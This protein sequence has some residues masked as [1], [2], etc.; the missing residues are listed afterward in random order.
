MPLAKKRRNL[1]EC[2]QCSD[3]TLKGTVDPNDG[4]FYCFICW[5]AFGGIPEDAQ[6]INCILCKKSQVPEM[7][8]KTQQKKKKPICKNCIPRRR[9][10][11]RTKQAQLQAKIGKVN[12]RLN[13]ETFMF[14]RRSGSYILKP[15]QVLTHRLMKNFENAVMKKRRDEKIC[16]DALIGVNNVQQASLDYRSKDKLWEVTS[17]EP[18]RSEV[19]D[20]DGHNKSVKNYFTFPPEEHS[21]EFICDYALTDPMHIYSLNNVVNN[22]KITFIFQP[23]AMYDVRN[24]YTFEKMRLLLVTIFEI[25]GKFFQKIWWPVQVYLE[26]YIGCSEMTSNIITAFTGEV[27]MECS[28]SSPNLGALFTPW[29]T[30]EVDVALMG[31]YKKTKKMVDTVGRS[32]VTSEEVEPNI[33]PDVKEESQSDVKET[34]SKENIEAETKDSA[35]CAHIVEK[36]VSS[37][38]KLPA[39]ETDLTVC[40]HNNEETSSDVN[41][42]ANEK[43]ASVEEDSFEFVEAAV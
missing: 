3:L 5:E 29:D 27:L 42:Q 36:K 19:S 17:E 32:T 9:Q 30:W 8:S 6:W 31:N 12:K 26:D 33:T 37:D 14:F 1:L 41:A 43:E 10:D 13:E 25:K 40:T 22:L 38:V 16:F 28:F 23:S 39:E 24:K 7:Y 35:N 2:G 4:I 34:S 11:A 20:G 21:G 15:K 18:K